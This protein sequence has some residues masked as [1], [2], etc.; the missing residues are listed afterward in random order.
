MD[1]RQSTSTGFPADV[2][3]GGAWV[4]VQLPKAA[5]SAV[6]LDSP[7]SGT[8]YPADFAY[9][10]SLRALRQAEDT[11][12]EALFADGPVL[13]A[14]LV[15]A[16]FPRAYIDPNR[17]LDDIDPQVLE[18]GWDGPISGSSNALAGM[19]L[20]WRLLDDG[21]PIYPA[22]V[23]KADQAERIRRCYLPYHDQVQKQ[24]DHAFALHGRALL[25]NCHS[26]PSVS[27][28]L[29]TRTGTSRVADIVLGNRDGT[30]CA[31]SITQRA[32]EVCAGLGLSVAI[33]DPYKG[34]E[35]VRRHGQPSQGRH[36]L[37][38]EINR[39]LYMDEATRQRSA[40]FAAIKEAMAALVTAMGALAF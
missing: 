29:T 13:G 34:V 11:H 18:G 3:A 37:Q 38:V 9:S 35:L 2:N 5:R 23:A 40:G 28:R 10:C 15:S 26:M 4:S 33:N 30:T 6:V 1:L 39:A 17:A 25:L 8:K 27:P 21:T 36:A 7:H 31:E 32:R 22:A 12:V 24:L 20:L 14:P 19:G 16:L